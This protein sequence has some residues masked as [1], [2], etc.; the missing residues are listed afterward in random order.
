M[1]L[2]VQIAR[3]H[4]Y[5]L[6]GLLGL[7]LLAAAAVAY[8]RRPHLTAPMRGQALALKLGCF[9]CH[10]PEGI[11]GISDPAS[12]SGRVP[13]WDGGIAARYVESEQDIREWI[14]DGAPRRLA[15]DSQ[16]PAGDRLS[17]R[18][19]VPMPAYRGLL[20][21]QDLD[22]LVAY[23]LAVSG[24]DP[25]MPDPPYEGK[26]VADRMGCFG[27]HGPSGRTGVPNPG[28]FKGYIPPWDG[29]DFGELVRDE[30]ELR[31]WILDGKTKRLDSH[32]VAR[33]FL[34]RQKIQMPA[35]RGY[36]SKE[37]LDKIVLYIQWLRGQ[38]TRDK[39]QGT[40]DKGQG[41][42]DKGQGDRG[43]KRDQ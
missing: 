24:W 34:E 6:L 37:E 14:L 43:K 29:D 17:P 12:K 36:L 9:G 31:E 18:P 3:R 5:W 21:S 15:A 27:C 32:P 20:S 38:G 35:Y 10:G 2:K 42:R 23:F 25:K 33:T 4:V 13:A 41:T 8:T 19:L 7:G 28:S 16:G 22:D 39:G 40:R 11:R 1:Q 30:T 26:K